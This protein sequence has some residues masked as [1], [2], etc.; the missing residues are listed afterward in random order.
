MKRHHTECLLSATQN[1]NLLVVVSKVANVGNIF[2]QPSPT[3]NN[4]CPVAFI[5]FPRNSFGFAD[6]ICKKET[7]FA[8]KDILPEH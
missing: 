1:A 2:P 3:S 6:K 4:L 7:D 5:G 8:R